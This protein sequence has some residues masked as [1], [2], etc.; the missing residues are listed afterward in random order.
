METIYGLGQMRRRLNLLPLHQHGLLPLCSLLLARLLRL[1]RDILD[2]PPIA[3]V[4]PA[5]P[6]QY[7]MVVPYCLTVSYARNDTRRRQKGRRH[8]SGKARVLMRRYC[9]QATFSNEALVKLIGGNHLMSFVVGHGLFR[10]PAHCTAYHF[11][12]QD[13]TLSFVCKEAK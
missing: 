7:R 9:R 5:L 3:T 8:E 13:A 11:R 10:R 12:P 4:I 1:L 2:E 6:I